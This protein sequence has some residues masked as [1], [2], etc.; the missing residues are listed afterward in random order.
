[1]FGDVWA[2][3]S[4]IEGYLWGRG[5]TGGFSGF[6]ISRFRFRSFRDFVERGVGRGRY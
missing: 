4:D 3:F 2:F 1:M 5:W 6:L